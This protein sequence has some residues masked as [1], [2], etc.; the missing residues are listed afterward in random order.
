MTALP[1]L[2]RFADPR[3][4][5]IAHRG[6]WQRAAGE[7]SLGALRDCAELGIAAAEVDIRLTHD[8]ELM[9][10]HDSD[11]DR[12]TDHTGPFEGYTS[13]ELARVRIRRGSGD[14]TRPSPTTPSRPSR[15]RSGSPRA[16]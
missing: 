11:L 10:L 7:N 8:G 6:C 1:V 3:P 16:R 5:V 4:I 14:Q 9:L 13:H 2:K 15:R 12:T